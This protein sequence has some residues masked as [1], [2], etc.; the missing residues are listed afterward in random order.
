MAHALFVDDQPVFILDRVRQALPEHQVAVATSGI[1]S[2]QTMRVK[3]CALGIT[4][5]H[6]IELD[7]HTRS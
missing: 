1:I 6:S 4:V 7:D 3:L 2:R 5:R